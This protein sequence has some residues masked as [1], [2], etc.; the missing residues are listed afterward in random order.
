M[1]SFTFGPACHIGIN[2]VTFNV[3]C[4]VLMLNVA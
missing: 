3:L 4:N 2:I 1:F